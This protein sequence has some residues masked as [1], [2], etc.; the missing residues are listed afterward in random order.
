ML[1]LFLFINMTSLA[2]DMENLHLYTLKTPQMWP[3]NKNN[4]DY[5]THAWNGVPHF[6]SFSDDLC[7][8]MSLGQV[9]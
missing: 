7:Q 6:Q 1:V 5:I 2:G 9:A 8:L 4:D 3:T